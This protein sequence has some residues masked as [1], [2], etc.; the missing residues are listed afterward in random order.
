MAETA[1]GTGS[2]ANPLLDTVLRFAAC[3]RTSDLRVSTAEILDT[4]GQL[5]LIDPLDETA[6]K[7]L[8]GANFV[9]TR[10]DEPRFEALYQLFF[11]DLAMDPA[12]DGLPDR[13]VS[14]AAG[15]ILD[16]LRQ[17][18]ADL[19]DEAIQTDAVR[20]ALIDFLAGQPQAWLNLLRQLEQ[21]DD[22]TQ[23]IPLRSNLGELSQRLDIMLKINRMR[24]RTRELAET[25]LSDDPVTRRAVDRHFRFLLDRADNLFRN[26]PRPDNAGL[27][28]VHTH[29]QRFQNL[30]EKPLANL[31]PQEI[32]S[33][34]DIIER[35][36]NKLRD[37]ASRRQAARRRGAL[38]VT[39]TLRRANRSLGVPM[40]LVYKTRPPRKGK[41]VTLCD[42]SGSVWSTARFMLSV[43]YA[44]QDCFSGVKS[45]VF[46]AGVAEVTDLFQDHDINT[47]IEKIFDDNRL[48][49]EVP[50]DYGETFLRFREHHLHE[51]TRRTTL[52]IIGD[53]RSN[54]MNPRV[55]V[56]DEMRKKCRRVIWLNPEALITWDNGDSDMRLFRRYCH[57]IRPCRNLNQLWSFVEDL[58]L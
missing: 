40:S 42:V 37:T 38:D 55:D 15:R 2:V 25:D 53:G 30:G 51:L 9:K 14:A 45:F 4:V 58:V 11:H 44:L 56:L 6:F 5:K 39:A 41:I 26:E 1:A 57:E 50:T 33:I 52:I 7:T 35:L 54:Y 32:E 47:A 12:A 16:E 20:E 36:V 24:A 23:Q 19:G 43:L 8:L 31:T 17:P 46:V 10:R 21:S 27:R 18:A 13:P 29:E 34:R 3:C 49:T 22:Q 48:A 28:E